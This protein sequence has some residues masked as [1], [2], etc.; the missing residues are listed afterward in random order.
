MDRV[1]I[2]LGF[3]QIY[4]YSIF[5]AIGVLFGL[6][7]AI[8]E[9][10]RQ[11]ISKDFIIDAI[12]WGLPIGIIGA[13]I[14]YVIFSW[15]YY[16]DNLIDI[17]KINEGGLAIH[18]GII[19]GF[20]FAYFYSKKKGYN[21]F[22]IVDLFSI[23]FLVGQMFGR[24]GNFINKE[25]YGPKVSLE[26]LQKIKIPNFIIEGMYINGQYH[27][28]TF[29][30]ESIWNLIGLVILFFYRKTKKV[31]LGEMTLLYLMWYSLGRYFIE[32]L[33]TDS[34]M[35]GQFKIAKLISAGLFIGSAI[36]LTFIKLK[37]NKLYNE[38]VNNEN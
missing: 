17:L 34:L 4:W 27:H 31:K 32:I 28:P 21:P 18:G 5:I 6:L 38:G 33:R 22:K 13:R 11:N 24:W 7:L 20:I 3:I 8:K 2:N 1:A 29:F 25:A 15:S 37:S 12:L 10:K 35:I 9:A 16:K 19:A 14:Y 26:F 30:Y 36:I 23:S